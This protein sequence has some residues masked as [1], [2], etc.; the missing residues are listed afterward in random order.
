ML[1]TKQ[2]IAI[3]RCGKIFSVRGGTRLGSSRWLGKVSLRSFPRTKA[4]PD[5]AAESS[6]W[7]LW[8]EHY[9]C[10]NSGI[11]GASRE[12]SVDFCMAFHSQAT[13]GPTLY[14][15]REGG[16]GGIIS[17]SYMYMNS[18]VWEWSTE[19]VVRILSMIVDYQAS[20]QLIL[21]RI[22]VFC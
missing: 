12:R 3:W 13:I 9:S 4:G 7:N 8:L 5:R 14:G 15:G 18:S 20:F 11:N 10:A 1:R 6:L 21:T 19:F 2:G 16:G 17:S 22:V